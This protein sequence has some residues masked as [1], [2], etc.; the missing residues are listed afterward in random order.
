MPEANNHK[1]EARKYFDILFSLYTSGQK[2]FITKESA[3]LFNPK[4]RQFLDHLFF[5][6]CEGVIK[7]NKIIS[8]RP[9]KPDYQNYKVLNIDR[10]ACYPYQEKLRRLL[11]EAGQMDLGVIAQQS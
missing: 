10:H 3:D 4:D 11:D 5:H 8:S 7:I 2:I 6:D 9:V 1:S